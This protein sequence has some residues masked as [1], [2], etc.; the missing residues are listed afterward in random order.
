MNT[1]GLEVR[2][3]EGSS[4]VVDER[5]RLCYEKQAHKHPLLLMKF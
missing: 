1:A 5:E 2:E 3:I 4:T